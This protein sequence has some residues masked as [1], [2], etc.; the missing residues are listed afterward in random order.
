MLSDANALQEVQGQAKKKVARL[1]PV[2]ATSKTE[3]YFQVCNF[4]E[5]IQIGQ[6]FVTD[7][8]NGVRSFAISSTDYKSSQ[9]RLTLALACYFDSLYDM[10]ILVISDSLGNG[11]YSALAKNLKPENRVLSNGKRTVKVNR[12]TSNIELLSLNDLIANHAETD[13]FKEMT[14]DFLAKYD[15]IF[16]DNPT[17]NIHKKDFKFY[18]VIHHF[19]ESLTVI[20]SQSTSESKDERELVSYFSSFGID[21]K[22][23]E[24]DSAQFKPKRKRVK[25]LGVIVK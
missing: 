14:H 20:V 25:D 16:W 3:Y 15:A 12:F 8:N 18:E 11:P 4:E 5:L 24:F 2:D 10:R 22:G 6:S 19:F 17:F 23:V 1:R 13:G 21:V 9:Q 7:F